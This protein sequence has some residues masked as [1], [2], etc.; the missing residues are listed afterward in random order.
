MSEA[1][2]DGAG[3]EIT[4]EQFQTWVVAQAVRNALEA[5]HGGGAFDPDNPDSDEGFISDTQMRALNIVIRRTVH[6][7]LGKLSDLGGD[8]RAEDAGGYCWFQ[9]SSVTGYM[10]PPGSPEL[11]EA[12]REVTR[13]PSE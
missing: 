2:T 7:A 9:L 1:L 5:F 6:E 13:E 3:R 12:Y 10:E 4:V 8:K 11:E